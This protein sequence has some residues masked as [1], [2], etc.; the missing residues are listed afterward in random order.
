MLCELLETLDNGYRPELCPSGHWHS[1]A[2]DKGASI[3]E[4]SKI[5][6]ELWAKARAKSADTVVS[7]SEIVRQAL[8]EWVK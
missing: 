8:E 3:R 4:I 5:P 1:V 7:I 6:D 2:S